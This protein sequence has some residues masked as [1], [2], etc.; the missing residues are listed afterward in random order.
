MHKNRPNVSRIFQWKM[1]AEKEKERNRGKNKEKHHRVIRYSVLSSRCRRRGLR[2]KFRAR[3]KKEIKKEKKG[4]RRRKG[5]IG[6]RGW[7]GLGVVDWNGVIEKREWVL[8]ET[9]ASTFVPYGIEMTHRGWRTDEAGA[10]NR[11]SNPRF[12][13]SHVRPDHVSRRRIVRHASRYSRAINALVQLDE[14]AGASL[15][16]NDWELR[17][18][19]RFRIGDSKDRSLCSLESFTTRTR[20][21]F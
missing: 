16:L 12:N 5:E 13:L 1:H 17:Q 11:T 10:A 8:S 2:N 7:P 4:K 21:W 15:L 3:K 20:G 18:R 19:D 6:W 14:R 9:W